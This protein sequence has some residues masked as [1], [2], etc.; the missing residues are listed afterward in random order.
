MEGFQVT[1]PRLQYVCLK[2]TAPR[3]SLALLAYASFGYSRHQGCSTL[4]SC[5][6]GPGESEMPHTDGNRPVIADWW[7]PR[8]GA[9]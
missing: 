1:K 9:V 4:F 6:N 3:L 5:A 7:F 2:H 8:R